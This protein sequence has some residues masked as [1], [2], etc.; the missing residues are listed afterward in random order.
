M[1][2]IRIRMKT[3]GITFKLAKILQVFFYLAFL[4]L[5]FKDNFQL[6][7]KWPISY[8]WALIPLAMVSSFRIYVRVKS[9]PV[10]FPH[11]FSKSTVVRL[12][13]GHLPGSK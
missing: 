13:V 1:T 12:M 11:L 2:R 6:L 4:F 8:L 7:K 5:W 3:A 10:K 9:K